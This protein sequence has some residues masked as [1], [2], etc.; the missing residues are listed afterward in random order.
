MDADTSDE[1]RHGRWKEISDELK[2]QQ[3]LSE[4][5][6]DWER[7][8]AHVGKE[9]VDKFRAVQ[10]RLIGEERDIYY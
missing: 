6:L 4:S 9:L 3:N 7:F 2:K 10:T 5:K 8:E 1:W